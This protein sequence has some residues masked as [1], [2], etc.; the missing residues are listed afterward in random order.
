MN[1]RLVLLFCALLFAIPAHAAKLKAVK[2]LDNVPVWL[3]EDHSLPM[4]A[5]TASFPAGSAYDPPGKT[6]M[7]ALAAYLLNEGAGIMSADAYQAALA[8]KG[9]RLEMTPSRDWLTIT[10]ITVTANAKEAFRLLGLALAKPRFDPDAVTRVR[11]QL[12]QSYDR[13]RENPDFVAETG[14]YSIFFGPYTYGRPVEGDSRGLASIS[15]QELHGFA[16]THWVRGDLRIAVAGDITPSVLAGYVRSTFGSL[17][18]VAPPLPAVPPRVG[19]PGLHTLPMIAPQPAVVFGQA[20]ML[21]SD[22]DY[23][24]GM[25]ANYILGGAGSGSRLTRELREQRG[26]TYDVTTDL[27]AYRRAGLVLGTVST[28]RDG[29]RETL[30]LV[31]EIMRKFAINGPTEQELADAKLYLNGSFPLSFTS[32]AAT[33]AQLNTFQQYGLPLDYLDHRTAMIDAVTM[34]DVRRVARRL[35]DPARL[36]IVL[37]GSLPTGN[38]E[39][40]DS[41]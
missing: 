17:P 15:A 10:L 28:R 29:A 32:N 4:I 33:A 20:G 25:I 16:Q 22:R 24:A 38:T 14:F 35:F 3:A 37:A 40:A 6:G 12:M 26:L 1:R 8:A 7:A 13:N 19:A 23:L 2:A 39:P 41:P 27:V 18:A 5:L 30:T 11:L 31:R 21:R 9:I 36:T 34:A